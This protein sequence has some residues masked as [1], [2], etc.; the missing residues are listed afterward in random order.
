M[1][2]YHSPEVFLGLGVDS[3]VY[4]HEKID[5]GPGKEDYLE[6]ITFRNELTMSREF[7]KVIQG[8]TPNDTTRTKL[9]TTICDYDNKGRW[10]WMSWD[11]P[12]TEGLDQLE[13][14]RYN[15]DG[16]WI[17]T[18]DYGVDGTDKIIMSPGYKE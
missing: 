15:E 7:Y 16:E 12:E 14:K 10:I 11:L 13:T 9:S 3:I 4:P 18:I 8:L 6:R 5:I 1:E 2:S 17:H